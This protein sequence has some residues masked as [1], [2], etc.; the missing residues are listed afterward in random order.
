M[1][2]ANPTKREEHTDDVSVRSDYTGLNRPTRS[3]ELKAQTNIANQSAA[4][5]VTG[6][7]RY[8]GNAERHIDMATVTNSNWNAQKERRRKRADYSYVMVYRVISHQHPPTPALS[9]YDYHIRKG[10]AHSACVIGRDIKAA[11]QRAEK[12]F[13]YGKQR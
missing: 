10:H 13:R 2:T 3:R 1:L 6:G 9:G 12:Q 8:H 4:S 5:H 11:E 7:G